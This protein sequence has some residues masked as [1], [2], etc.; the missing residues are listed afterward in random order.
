MCMTCGWILI[1]LVLH[2]VEK[3][4]NND[5]Q[6]KELTHKSI[7]TK[8]MDS[9]AH[10]RFTVVHLVAVWLIFSS[11]FLPGIALTFTH[12]PCLCCSVLRIGFTYGNIKIGDV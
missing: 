12:Q 9:L 7:E 11:E 8:Y 4:N 1:Y 6:K 5:K 2:Q 10:H 3:R